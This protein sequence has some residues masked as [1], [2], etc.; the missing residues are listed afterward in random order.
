MLN[1]PVDLS[2]LSYV[3]KNKFVKK[4]EY[5]ELVT[6]PNA[7][8][9]TDTSNLVKKADYNTKINEIEEKKPNHG[10]Y[11]TTQKFKKLTAD[12]FAA[13]LKKSEISN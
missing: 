8:Q 5:N 11:I 1:F 4:S 9:T 3:V 2:K 12:N 10:K 13:R 6:K 7:I